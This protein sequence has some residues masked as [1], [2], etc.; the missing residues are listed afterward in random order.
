MATTEF[1][2]SI[3]E[4]DISVLQD[5]PIRQTEAGVSRR[6]E[7]QDQVVI[8]KP[9][10][11]WNPDEDPQ[12]KLNVFKQ[13]A[14]FLNDIK[15]PKIVKLIGMMADSF[16]I[17]LEYMSEGS[18]DVL[19]QSKSLLSWIDRHGLMM[20]VAEGMTY[21][22]SQAIFNAANKDAYFHKNLSSAN[23]L[24]EYDPK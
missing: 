1:V 17:V 20:D 9:M 2:K 4:T 6:G 8:I 14:A 21:L 12:S 13:E 19:I 11:K 18:L 24:L 5:A 16:C 3:Q 15:H 7:Y 23:I 22:H 10:L